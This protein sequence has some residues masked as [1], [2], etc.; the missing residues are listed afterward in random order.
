MII[1]TVR[2]VAGLMADE[3]GGIN[4]K[5]AA[6]GLDST[7]AGVEDTRPADINAVI[8]EFDHDIA[9]RRQ[10]PEDGGQAAPYMEVYQA[11][12]IEGDGWATTSKVDSGSVPIA[13]MF[14]I[15]D[16]D[17]ATANL[18]GAY[19]T[20]CA[21]QVINSDAAGDSSNRQRNSIQVIQHSTV[22]VVPPFVPIGSEV[23]TRGMIVTFTT[24]DLDAT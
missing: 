22:T 13:I 19:Y 24:R 7:V 15:R 14:V 2:Y 12:E 1:E 3:T 5:L 20:R 10:V 21:L 11:T 18:A 16:S 9:A 4:V 23:T 17:T 6:I 8:N